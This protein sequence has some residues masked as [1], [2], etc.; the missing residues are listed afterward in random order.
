MMFSI[1]MSSDL[2]DMYSHSFIFVSTFLHMIMGFATDVVRDIAKAQTDN[3]L[4][5][6]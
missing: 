4:R 1:F 5:H 2:L 3:A 6:T